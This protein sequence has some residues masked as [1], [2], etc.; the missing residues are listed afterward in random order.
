[1]LHE[2]IF[3]EYYTITTICYYNLQ[4]VRYYNSR[5]LLIQFM[6][7]ITIHPNFYYNLRQVLNVKTLLQFTT[8]HAAL[9]VST[10]EQEE[11]LT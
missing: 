5:Q 10:K 9:V 6:T 7:G 8:V 2:A 11:C 3:L 4:Q 1:M